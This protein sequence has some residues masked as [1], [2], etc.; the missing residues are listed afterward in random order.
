MFEIPS[1][2][3]LTVPKVQTPARRPKTVTGQRIA[4]SS[5]RYPWWVRAENAALWLRGEV[6]VVRTAKMACAVF[7]ISYP[8]L[9]KVQARLDR[10]KHG[11]GN[12]TGTMVLSDAVIDNMIM[13]IGP[14]RI[15]AALDRVTQ[16]QL[17]LEPAG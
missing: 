8:R 10:N 15:L 2:V 11:N 12:G 16:P 5:T 14:D 7:A 1:S 3:T 13:E 9:K 4:K 17:P 6:E